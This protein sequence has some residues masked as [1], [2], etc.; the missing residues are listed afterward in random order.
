MVETDPAHRS[1][2]W[3][4]CRLNASPIGNP[5]H[6][7][8]SPSRNFTFLC[9]SGGV[10]ADGDTAPPPFLGYF[11][12]ACPHPFTVRW[13]HGL[14]LLLSGT[15]EIVQLLREGESQPATA[16]QAGDE[17]SERHAGDSQPG[18]ECWLQ[19][20]RSV[21][22]WGKAAHLCPQMKRVCDLCKPLICLTDGHRGLNYASCPLSPCWLTPAAA[23]AHGSILVSFLNSE[24]GGSPCS[25]PDCTPVGNGCHSPLGDQ[26]Q[27]THTHTLTA[28]RE[29]PKCFHC[30]QKPTR[31]L[32]LHACPCTRTTHTHSNTCT[33]TRVDTH[34]CSNTPKHNAHTHTH[35]QTHAATHTHTQRHTRA[36][37][38]CRLLGTR[39][40]EGALEEE[41]ALAVCGRGRRLRVTGPSCR[42]WWPSRR[43]RTAVVPQWPSRC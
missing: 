14:R 5:S 36:C 32:S 1:Y 42:H 16:G 43:A 10:S 41:A 38:V 20:L 30:P 24:A 23:T 12:P 18:K 28:T 4:P 21:Q 13:P 37:C 40:R 7:I 31:C 29:R 8:V 39:G 11:S 33:H 35:T 22:G 27:I 2:C 34:T 3:E 25:S 15:A 26:K 19:E 6:R 17:H 9:P